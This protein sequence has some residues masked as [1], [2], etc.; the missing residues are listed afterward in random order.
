MEEPQ[1]PPLIL[2]NRACMVIRYFFLSDICYEEEKKKNSIAEIF[3]HLDLYI[4]Y[5]DDSSFK[6]VKK[7]KIL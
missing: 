2:Q 3:D 7:D 4:A 5:T 1:P 6:K